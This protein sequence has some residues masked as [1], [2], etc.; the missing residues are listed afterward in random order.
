MA[1]T[2]ADAV[3]RQD[4]AEEASAIVSAAYALAAALVVRARCPTAA[5]EGRALLVELVGD[6]FDE[7]IAEKW[8]DAAKGKG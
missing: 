1:Q 8:P 3:L 2:Y 6:S 5:R 7:L 4:A